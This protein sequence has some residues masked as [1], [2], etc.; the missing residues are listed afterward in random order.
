MP[1]PTPVRNAE[2][3]LRN[4]PE[5]LNVAQV[6]AAR[7]ANPRRDSEADD[8]AD[9]FVT[10][11]TP[12]NPNVYGKRELAHRSDIQSLLFT[13][14][15]SPLF[16]FQ[17]AGRLSLARVGPLKASEKAGTFTNVSQ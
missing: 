15:Y 6:M 17:R 5:A 3:A 9:T 13:V 4:R 7:L 8:W 14:L 1:P 10:S 16:T 11:P 12:F 2:E